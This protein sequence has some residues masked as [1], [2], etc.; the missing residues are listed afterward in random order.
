MSA[1]DSASIVE[2]FENI[3]AGRDQS[4]GHH[5]EAPSLLIKF[6]EDVNSLTDFL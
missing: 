2:K 1:P 3:L 4:T 5:E 6:L